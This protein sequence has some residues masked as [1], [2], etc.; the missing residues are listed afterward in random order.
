MS[1]GRLDVRK[2]ALRQELRARRV[3]LCAEDR[4]AA[5]RAASWVALQGLPWQLR[6]KVALFWPL[7]DEIDTRPLLHA[8]HWL[9]AAPLLPRMNGTGRALTFHAWR[10]DL[11]LVPGP[12]QVLEPPA[13]QAVTTPDIVLTPLLGFDAKGGRLGYGAGF[14]DVTF[15]TMAAA[16]AVPLRVGLC[17]ACQEVA[18]VPVGPADV[19]LELI[20]TEAGLR[21]AA[22]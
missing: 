10:P 20:I 11:E 14:Y 13:A 15:A 21:R 9:G 22:P 7:A 18:E 2:R 16:G 17:F 12:F 3:A 4:A 8:L 6:P 1:A 5:S 19:T